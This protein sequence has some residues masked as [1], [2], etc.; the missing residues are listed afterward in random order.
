MG[1]SSQYTSNAQTEP[2]GCLARLVPARS[3]E[4]ALIVTSN[5]IGY[6]AFLHSN[7]I[8]HN[9]I[10]PSNVLIGSHGQA[11]LADYG[12]SGVDSS[13][14][15]LSITPRNAYKIHRAPETATTTPIINP[16]TEVYQVG[17]TAFRLL[18][19][20]SLVTK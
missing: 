11:Q 16:Q 19:G 6:S 17:I 2:C 13:G 18:N 5:R 10:K 12:I 1:I 14:K 15:S 8:Y 3:A 9:D 7:G 20:I 4:I